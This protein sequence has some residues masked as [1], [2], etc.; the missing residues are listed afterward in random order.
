M[1]L[2]EL[3]NPFLSSPIDNDIEV[4]G[5]QLDSRHIVPGDLFFAT[6]GS[7]VDGRAYIAEAIAKGAVAV[8][9]E[10]PVSDDVVLVS[11]TPM[12]AVENLSQQVSAIA[13]QFYGNPSHYL[14][15]VGVT[16]TNGKSSICFSLVSLLNSLGVKSAMIGTVG[17][18]FPGG[19][20]T[21]SLT[22]PN[23]IEVQK[24]LALFLEQGAEV[25]AMEVSS[26]ALCQYRIEGVTFEVAVFTNLTRDHLDYHGSMECYGA[27]KRQ[28]CTSLKPNHIVLNAD[29]DY[30]AATAKEVTHTNDI[31][32]YSVN[33]Q[34]DQ[35]NCCKATHVVSTVS[36]I[37]T[38]VCLFE[39]K[40]QLELNAVGI[41]SLSNLLAVLSVLSVL[42]VNL[43]SIATA[44]KNLPSVPGRMESF[45]AEGLPTVFVDYAHTPDAMEH[46]LSELKSVCVGKLYCIFGCGGDR[47]RGKRAEMAKI[48]A[49]LSD[50]CVVTNDNPRNE[51]PEQ[52]IQDIVNGFEDMSK[53]IVEQ[54]RAKAIKSTMMM[55]S[56]NDVIL[57]AG[58]G[59]EA[60]QLIG[61][62]RLPFSD[63]AEVQ[64]TLEEKRCS[65]G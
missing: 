37:S 15:V 50:I 20:E 3:L 59:H 51:D 33:E 17:V 42:R 24:L 41:F 8:C 25:V 22:T 11:D 52:I 47:D 21:S 61:D 26:H 28:L 56:D 39:E 18:G 34:C 63:V 54:D 46:V 7:N 1:K 4:L 57:V 2:S 53:V 40:I 35:P 49:E 13:S 62:Q 12:I 48:A 9:V 5:L 36:S 38:E 31:A 44:I 19:F 16:G 29:D 23:P 65:T 58:K 14:K 10:D 45:A 30:A 55:A 27:A 64:K 43:E 6:I 60:Y 32:F